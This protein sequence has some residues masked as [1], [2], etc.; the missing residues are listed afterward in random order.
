MTEVE[1]VEYLMI[2]IDGCHANPEYDG[3]QYEPLQL[4]QNIPERITASIFAE[5]LLGLTS[6]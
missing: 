3:Q 1:L 6:T 4:L 5:D 2:V